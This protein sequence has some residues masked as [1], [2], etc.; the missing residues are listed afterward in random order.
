MDIILGYLRYTSV[1]FLWGLSTYF[2]LKLVL[3]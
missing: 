3:K 2:V 1:F